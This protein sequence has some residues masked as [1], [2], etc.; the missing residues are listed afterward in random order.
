MSYT[1]ALAQKWIN[2]EPYGLPYIMNGSKWIEKIV[3][4]D[5]TGEGETPRE[6]FERWVANGRLERV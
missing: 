1:E 3:L 4:D 6:C 5:E 2:T